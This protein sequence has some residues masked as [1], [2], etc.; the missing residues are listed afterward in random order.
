MS[1]GKVTLE[2]PNLLIIGVAKAATTSLFRYLAQHPDIFPSDVKEL[3]YFTPLRYD[4][5]LEP[6]E[7][8]SIHFQKR[9]QERYA[10]EATPGYFPGGLVVAEGIDQTLPGARAILSLRDPRDRCWSY[11][12]F[13]KSRVRIPQDMDFDT[14]LDR[15]EELH[16]AGVDSAREHQPFWGLGGGCYD[17]WLP[18]WADVFDDRLRIVFFDD[19]MAE[20]EASVTGI[21]RW[22]DLDT[23]PVA[24]FDYAPDNRSEQ[25][26]HKTLQLAA[27]SLNRRA[28]QFFTRHRRLKTTMKAL[29]HRTNSRA[30][31]DTPSA[32]SWVRLAEFYR[33]RCAALSHQLTQIG[34]TRQPEWLRQGDD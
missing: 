31:V 32:E 18:S 4:E 24:H 17:A 19:V 22:L 21:C 16:R 33:P 10:V 2:L 23:T 15:C 7:N 11:F 27:L 14:Y 6:I 28:E 12:R 34:V 25:Y 30:L 13:V 3:R 8:Y 29:Y 9:T 20:P 5:P 1:A 26:R